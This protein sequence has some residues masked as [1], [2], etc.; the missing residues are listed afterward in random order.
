MNY[1]DIIEKITDTLFKNFAIDNF[2]LK[3]NIFEKTISASRKYQYIVDVKKS[4]GGYSLHLILRLLD[5]NISN[6]VNTILKKV[7]VDNEIEYPNNWTQKDIESSIKIRTKN[8]TILMLTDWR[9]FKQSNESLEEFNEK[10]SIWF[11]AFNKI[12]EKENWKKQ[13]YLSIEF[14]K[15][16]L[17]TVDDDKYIIENSIYESLYLLKINNNIEYLEKKYQ[18]NKLKMR[19]DRKEYELFYKYLME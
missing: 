19:G 1:K 17:E 15:K 2:V 10:F 9:I 6:G 7:L 12:E 16:W 8:N 5:K 13:L 14:T 4:H 18:E 3:N 11:C